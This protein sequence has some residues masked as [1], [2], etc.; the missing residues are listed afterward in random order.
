V[1]IAFFATKWGFVPAATIAVPWTTPP[2]IN[3]F[4]VT[5]SWRGAVL[6]I[7][8]IVVA[9]CIY[10]P[11]LSMA[12]RMAKQNEQKAALAVQSEQSPVAQ[13]EGQKVEV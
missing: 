3:G 6:S 4:L 12:N 10:L 5:Q 13:S 11:F 1:T 7:V 8:L 9:I 2:I